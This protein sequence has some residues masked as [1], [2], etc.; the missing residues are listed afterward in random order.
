LSAAWKNAIANLLVNGQNV[1]LDDHWKTAEAVE[2][3]DPAANAVAAAAIRNPAGPVDARLPRA[4]AFQLQ[5]TSA[6][7]GQ[8]FLLLAVMSSSRDPL[9]IE[10]LSGATVAD[11]V[12]GSRHVC[13]CNVMEAPVNWDS[14]HVLLEHLD[15]A[16]SS[17]FTEAVPATPAELTNN[18]Y[19]AALPGTF[20][21]AGLQTLLTA[22]LNKPAFRRVRSSL[23]ISL[24]DLSGANKFAP[25][26]AG[27]NDRSNFYA[28]STGKVSA[29][30]AAYQLMADANHLLSVDASLTSFAA[31]ET[32]L[33]HDWSLLGN[34]A[35]N[36]PDVGNVIEW[37]PGPPRAV[38]LN[39][40]L[41]RRFDDISAGN[42]NGSTAIV[43]MKFP[44]IASTLLAHGLF[45]PVDRTGLW[46]R[47]A[48]GPINYLGTPMRISSWSARENPFPGTPSNSVSA[49]AIAQFLTLAAQGRMIDS[50]TSRAILDHLEIRK[51][52]CATN[53]PDI[54]ALE[55]AG[56][57]SVKCGF[58]PQSPPDVLHVPLHFKASAGAREFVV[59]ILT[60]NSK[61]DVVHDLFDELI[62]LVP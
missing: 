54:A 25:K 43:L 22:I 40:E 49:V 24:V 26:Y 58:F 8:R 39:A 2:T 1:T 55:A 30:L 12:L 28:A 29:L 35:R 53:L 44:F 45:S 59:V 14:S 23:A 15:K 51:G 34:A 7:D 9:R 61:F 6:P 10:E 41:T 46:C 3:T 4:A 19:D 27:H 48:Y 16:T 52:G 17:M 36:Q 57:V 50:A 60:R 21:D 33:R 20:K 47:A 13:A 31:L 37:R 42:Q 11:V 62:A 18:F 38:V 56:S 32:R 5:M